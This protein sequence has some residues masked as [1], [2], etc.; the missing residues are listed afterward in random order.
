MI[1]KKTV[2]TSLLILTFIW[3]GT[4]LYG[5]LSRFVVQ[6]S[7]KPLSRKALNLMTRRGYCGSGKE[8]DPIKNIIKIMDTM[9]KD[10]A[11]IKESVDW[12]NLPKKWYNSTPVTIVTGFSSMGGLILLLEYGSKRIDRHFLKQVSS[13]GGSKV[14]NTNQ[15]DDDAVSAESSE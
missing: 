4:P 1:I 2:M 5:M 10:L 12:I 15:D 11:S 13:N 3:Q 6:K 14:D 7:T 8:T 9:Q